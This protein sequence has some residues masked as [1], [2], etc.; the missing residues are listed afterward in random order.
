MRHTRLNCQCLPAFVHQDTGLCNI[1]PQRFAMC[2]TWDILTDPTG[3]GSRSCALA[4][5]LYLQGRPTGYG[6]WLHVD[7]KLAEAS[8]EKALVNRTMPSIIKTL[9]AQSLG[10]KSQ[11]VP[12]L[13]TESNNSSC[14][15]RRSIMIVSA[16][17]LLKDCPRPS[18]RWP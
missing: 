17:N 11:L 18:R 16:Q 15:S 13:L 9:G 10:K 4:A 1:I 8:E 5:R 14:E 12:K 7:C 6:D 3:V 2:I